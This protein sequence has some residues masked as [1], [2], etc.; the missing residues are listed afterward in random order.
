MARP[1]K[2][3]R[4]SVSDPLE[5]PADLTRIDAQGRIENPDMTT[6]DVLAEATM[7]RGRPFGGE[8]DRFVGARD[9]FDVAADY[10]VTDRPR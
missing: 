7:P 9:L 6:T 5:P 1:L 4:R 2:G 3:A 8:K 10:T